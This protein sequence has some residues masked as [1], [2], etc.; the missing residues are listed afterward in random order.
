MALTQDF[1]SIAVTSPLGKDALLFCRMQGHEELGRLFEYELDVFSRNPDIK[2]DSLLGHPVTVEMVRSDGGIRHFNGFTARFSH[3][4]IAGDLT[5]YRLR[6]RPWLW[7]LTRT[8]DCR[9]FQ[10]KT[11]P[12]IIKQI[13]QELG[14]SDLKDSL[15]G[16]YRERDYCVQYRESD[17]NFISRLM[18]EEGIYYFFRHEAGRHT[19]VLADSAS[20]HSKVSGYDAIPYFPPENEERRNRDHLFS[21]SFTRKVKSGAFVLRDFDFE[22]PRADLEIKSACGRDHPK[23]DY[24]CFDYPG[25]Y[26]KPDEG[27]SYVDNRLGEFQAQHEVF[28]GEGNVAGLGVGDLFKLTGH[29]RQDQ[30][31]EYLVTE[32]AFE[33]ASNEYGPATAVGGFEGYRCTLSGIAKSQTF[34]PARLTP[35]PSVQGPQT[36]IV[37]GK[38]GEEIWTDK[39]GRVKVKFHWDRAE[40]RDE[41]SS[42]WIRVSHPWA[43]KNWGMISLPRI[44]QEVVVDFLEGDPDRPIITGRVY[45]AEQMPP[46]ALPSNATQSGILS[47]SSKDASASNFNELRFEDKQGSEEVY[48]HAEKDL[49][50]LVENDSTTEVGFDKKNPG[51]QTTN[52]YNNRSTTLDNGSDSLTIKVG[53][54]TTNVDLGK[55]STQA[56]QSIELKVGQNSLIIDQTGITIKG[57]MIRIEGTTMAELK[58]LMTTVSGDAMLTNKGGVIM[59]N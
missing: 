1:R 8:T 27:Q 23:S 35:K 40:N 16:A 29:P 15:T 19:L 57:M 9:I 39:Y 24:E 56:M 50:V 45:N 59:I 58:S 4:G 36:A 49:H 20:A 12:N 44:G 26:F 22:T 48:L 11:A 25:G 38:Q 21:W 37:V 47:R 43:G 33:M 53:D 55:I 34:R 52:I 14:F 51:N 13:F 7:F 2:A 42:C 17:F 3:I 5:R 10:Q 30:N 31:I 32:N 18:E 54:Q 41:T 46:Y 28:H 6:L